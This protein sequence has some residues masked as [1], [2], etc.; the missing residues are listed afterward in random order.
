MN[1]PAALLLALLLLSPAAPRAA[2]DAA[3]AQRL[4]AIANTWTGVLAPPAG[5]P[6]PAFT[7]EIEIVAATG[8]PQDLLGKRLSLAWQAPDRVKLSATV[9]D[10]TYSAGRFQNQLWLHAAGKQFGLVGSPDVPRFQADPTP[11][12]TVLPDFKLPVKREQILLLPLLCQ[13][14]AVPDLT[15]DGDACPGLRLT[16]RP[17]AR[18]AMKLPDF[19]LSVWVRSQDNGPARLTYRAGKTEVTLDFRRNELHADGLPDAA[20]Q[21][22]ARPGDTIETVALG[23]L[24]RFLTVAPR[25]LNQKLPPLGPATGE[26]RFIARHGKGRLEEHDGTRVLFLKGTP[27]E[28]GAQHGHLMKKSV[29]HLVDRILYG[30]G[31]GSSLIKGRWFFGEIEEAQARLQPF[32]DE[33]HLREMNALAQA[34]GVRIEEARLAN[35][36]PELFHCSGFA[37]YGKATD[38]GRLYHGRILDYMKGVGLEQNACVIVVQ[39]DQ[40]HAWVN[41]GYAGFL[42]TVTAMNEKHVAIGEMGGRG[43][44][45]WDGKPMAQLMREVMEKAATIDEAVEIM[46]TSPRTCEYYYVIS[47][48][49]THRAVGIAATPERFETIWAGESHPQL[50]HPIENTVL[51]SSGDRYNALAERVQAGY[52]R[53]DA[54]SARDLMTRPVCMTSNIQSVLFAPDTLDFWVANADSKNV[55]SHT[56]YTRYNLRELLDAEPAPAAGQ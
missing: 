19:T 51:M 54:D 27:E 4:L 41:L 31:V 55:A 2:D 15:L 12:G 6:A 45:N 23:H 24:T 38:G 40:G 10:E 26:R 14:E 56:R 33:R 47:D 1:K 9:K 32:T 49:K 35:F 42:G 36:F 44:G 21:I 20:W 8:A 34:S 18:T 28:M 17:E 50:P 11:D 46:R 48:A 7:T 16:P 53:F 5:S 25:M 13:V 37:L 29:H 43:E 30:V 3:L 39:P 22:P 52:G